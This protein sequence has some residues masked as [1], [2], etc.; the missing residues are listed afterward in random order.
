MKSNYYL[1][2]LITIFVA[3]E[4]KAQNEADVL[5]YSLQTY[6]GTAR[7]YGIGGAFGAI[8]GDL[9][10]AGINPAGLG[11][12]RNSQ[13]SMSAAF[14]N[15]RNDARFIDKTLSDK[16]FNFNLPNIALLINIPGEE[17]ENKN[18]NGFVNFNIGFNMNR[19][20]NFHGRTI[21]NANNNASSITQNWA[22]RANSNNS[23]PADFS[24]YSLEYLAYRAWA[25]D[26]DTSSPTPAY[27]S[28]YGRNPLIN[29]R[30]NGNILT[31]GA[32]NDYNVSFAA[33][34]SHL[35]HFGLTLGAKSVRYI[36]NNTFV[37]KDIKTANVKDIDNVVMNQYLRTT[38]TG[39]NAKF[40][41]TV[42]PNEFVRFGYAFHSPTVYNLKD[43][44]SYSITSVFDFG[45]IDQFGDTR[46]GQKVSTPAA[47]YS[48]KISTPARNIF[49]V[50]FINKELGFVS[51]DIESVNYASAN[52]SPTKENAS[53]YSFSEENLNINSLYKS[54]AMNI[55]IGGEYADGIY[56]YRAGYGMYS[57]PYSDNSINNA[58]D[59]KTRTYS[60]G[61]GIKKGSYS[62]DF[63]YINTRS[64]SLFVPY[65]LSKGTSYAITNNFVSNNLVFTAGFILD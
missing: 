41:I 7:S 49:S 25:I 50:G 57:S 59:F 54:N 28:A 3:F 56:R 48:Y 24:R 45:A 52:I 53:D 6:G 1:A 4:A 2:F 9:S 31:K 10:C 44:Y 27:L 26:K 5:R 51:M 43:S 21:F 47:T 14:Y 8:G 38:G 17:Y 13:F 11:R 39:F 33:N 58:S 19:L 42:T 60:L 32:I 64:A 15:I 34:Y 22:E 29:V 12:I 35:F 16:K 18:P 23:I 65:T 37:E 63:A 30:Q 62:F 36:E 61:F 40:G 20:N 46:V 55:R